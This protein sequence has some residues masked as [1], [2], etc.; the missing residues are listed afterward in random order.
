MWHF[1]LSL[2]C[3]Y[4]NKNQIPPPK[5]DQMKWICAV[6]TSFI[7]TSDHLFQNDVANFLCCSFLSWV[8]LSVVSQHLRGKRG[9]LIT[10]DSHKWNANGFWIHIK[11]PDG[12]EW[13]WK[14]RACFAC[15]CVT[16]G[17]FSVPILTGIDMYL[18]WQG[19]LEE[20]REGEKE[21]NEPRGGKGEIG[22]QWMKT[23]W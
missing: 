22:S 19:G 1:N 9:R 15:H 4:L 23:D 18:G 8:W 21:H 12:C 6:C 7:H 10:F 11:D 13:C 14:T 5:D 2:S 3:I 20:W 16:F 17:A